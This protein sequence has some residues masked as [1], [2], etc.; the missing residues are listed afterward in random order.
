M[1]VFSVPFTRGNGGGGGSARSSKNK[2]YDDRP[3]INGDHSVQMPMPNSVVSPV[4]SFIIYDDDIGKQWMNNNGN[5]RSLS[6]PASPKSNGGSLVKNPFQRSRSS[7]AGRGNNGG[8]RMRS[9]SVENHGNGLVWAT[10]IPPIS[11]QQMN[12]GSTHSSP[13][14]QEPIYSEPGPPPQPQFHHHHH[15]QVVRA[16]ERTA[17]ARLSYCDG[18]SHLSNHI[19]EYLVSRRS[20]ASTQSSS[21]SG[22]QRA[23]RTPTKN[24]HGSNIVYRGPFTGSAPSV[25]QSASRPLSVMAPPQTMIH[26][27]NPVHQNGGGM[28]RGSLTSSSSPSS[29]GSSNFGSNSNGFRTNSRMSVSHHNGGGGIVRNGG[30]KKKEHHQSRN[31]SSLYVFLPSSKKNKSGGY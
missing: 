18:Q 11:Q 6:N 10:N 31:F 16:A 7:S 25:F 5:N 8:S 15:S 24:H 2:R 22:S 19:Y 17:V 13:S 20:D 1:R 14:K 4:G 27:H 3:F 9:S 30:R 26:H 12:G 21:A 23:P 29:S 28:R